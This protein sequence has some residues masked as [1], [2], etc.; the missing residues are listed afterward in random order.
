MW[1]VCRGFAFLAIVWGPLAMRGAT[2]AAAERMFKEAVAE[3]GELRYVRGI[4][5]LLLEGE[6]EQMGRQQAALVLDVARRYSQ[7]PK[8]ILGQYGGGFL[9]PVVVGF[10]RSL[11]KDAPER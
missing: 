2:A 9:W 8:T 10:S 1:R 11:M 3:G 5:L 6:P 7:V 4:P